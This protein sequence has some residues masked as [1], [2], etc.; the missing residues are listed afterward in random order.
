MRTFI[1]ALLLALASPVVAQGLPSYYPSEGFQRTGL[2]DGIYADENRI[3]INDIPYQY[4]T[5]VVVHS[6]SSYRA[7]LSRVTTGTRVGYKMTREGVI[8]ELW[9]LPDNYKR[10]G[11]R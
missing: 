10:A 11:R 3:V 6:L 9:L 2:V 5:S 4:S 1:V 7:P 8:I